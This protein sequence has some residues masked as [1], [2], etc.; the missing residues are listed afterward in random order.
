[1][2]YPE[3]GMRQLIIEIRRNHELI[4][5]L[6][7]K[8]IRVRYKRSALGFLWA[9]LNPLFMMIILAIVFSQV[10]HTGIS[11]YAVFLIC[12][13]LPWTFFT[14]ALAYAVESIVANGDLLKKIHIDKSVFPVT[15]V[16]SNVINFLFSLVTLVVVL[17][18]FRFPFH[19]T[20]VYLPVPFVSLILFALGCGFILAMANVF[21]RDV[22]Q[23]L[24]V[25]LA[26]WFYVSPIIYNLDFVPQRYRIFFRLNPM[27]YILNGFRAAIYYGQLPSP[28]NIAM[29]VGCGV[30]ALFV[31]YRVFRR[32]QDTLVFYV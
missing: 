11:N 30:I 15:A 26:A 8:D 28:Q 23:T 25:V 31:G 24:Q 10:M 18:I 17:V 21:L 19:W 6:A 16:L 14:Q 29:T 7:L 3:N 1:L 13:L 12:A 2:A 9:L 27:V 4:W 5:A 32:Y 22:G 20:W